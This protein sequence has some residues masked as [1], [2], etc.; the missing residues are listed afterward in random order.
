VRLPVTKTPLE[1]TWLYHEMGRCH[2][3]LGN[4]ERSRE[5]GDR[6]YQEATSARDK[7]WLLSSSILIAQS[8]GESRRLAAWIPASVEQI[9]FLLFVYNYTFNKNCSPQSF[10]G[11]NDLRCAHMDNTR[12]LSHHSSL[13]GLLLLFLRRSKVSKKA[14]ANLYTAPNDKQSLHRQS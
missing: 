1:R 14:L 11:S 3:E 5:L 2:F 13:N 4:F 10:S 12:V 6:S 7:I 9:D 8:L